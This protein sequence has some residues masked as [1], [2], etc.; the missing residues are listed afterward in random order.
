MNRVIPI[1]HGSLYLIFM[2]VFEASCV[3]SRKQKGAILSITCA[4]S[5][6]TPRSCYASN[7]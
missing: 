3:F 2:K 6:K 4:S 7:K 1:F 5:L